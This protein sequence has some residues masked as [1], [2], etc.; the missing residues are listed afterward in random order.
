MRKVVLLVLILANIAS[1]L[2]QG[3]GFLIRVNQDVNLRMA[4]SLESE[5]WGYA[6]PG[7]ILHVIGDSN[8]WY[9]ILLDGE[10]EGEIVW[11][12]SWLDITRLGTP[13][14]ERSAPQP[15]PLHPSF[16]FFSIYQESLPSVVMLDTFDSSGTGFVIDR[17]G[18]IITNAH[19]VNDAS[20]IQVRFVD[21]ANRRGSLIALNSD[22][23]IAV[24]KVNVPCE[25][26]HPISFSQSDYVSVGQPV[27]GIGG[28]GSLSWDAITGHI[29]ELN[30]DATLSDGFAYSD[31]IETDLGASPGYSGGPLIDTRGEVIGVTFARDEDSTWSIPSAQVLPLLQ[32]IIGD[33]PRP[34]TFPGRPLD[35]QIIDRFGLYEYA[36]GILVLPFDDSNTLEKYGLVGHYE[37]GDSSFLDKAIYSE[38]SYSYVYLANIVFAVEGVRISSL[39]DIN[40]HFAE[41]CPGETVNLNVYEISVYYEEFDATATFSNAGEI[42][43]F[44]EDSFP[45]PQGS[46][47]GGEAYVV[48]VK[49]QKKAWNNVSPDVETIIVVGVDGIPV[50]DNIYGLREYML[51]RLGQEVTFN[52]L[53]LVNRTGEITVPISIPKR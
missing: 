29:K 22:L 42:H 18:H 16:D 44:L 45:I 30:V 34:V 35:L 52:A 6:D 49:V 10:Y 11:L 51:Q 48:G 50:K 17:H 31:L 9:K 43:S 23:D 46:L 39:S 38:Y 28:P 1:A 32:E 15:T 14:A 5:R 40:R 19:V 33:L 26:L 20:F 25:Q 36:S 8:G 4:P 27:L 47:R 21:G 2:A 13:P 37:T 3:S 53:A 12:A 24:V 7:K 41:A